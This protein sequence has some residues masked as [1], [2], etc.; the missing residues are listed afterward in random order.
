MSD[1][2]S[3]LLQLAGAVHPRSGS[4]GHNITSGIHAQALLQSS[5]KL[6][7]AGNYLHA[8]G[9]ESEASAADR[10]K[11]LVQECGVS[12]HKLSELVQELPPRRFGEV[13]IEFYFRNM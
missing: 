12:P 2:R 11:S 3:A 6:A 8:L 7:L 13:L 1:L 9:Q 5:S 4:P 10:L